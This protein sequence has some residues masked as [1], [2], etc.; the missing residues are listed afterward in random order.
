MTRAPES[1]RS[2]SVAN[3]RRGA[4]HHARRGVLLLLGYYNPRLHSG[5]MR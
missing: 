5:I 3:P 1:V 2:V 4:L